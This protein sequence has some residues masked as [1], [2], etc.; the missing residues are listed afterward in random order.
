[1]GVKLNINFY[2]KC[3]ELRGKPCSDSGEERLWVKIWPG[4]FSTDRCGAKESSG[5]T[6]S[7]FSLVQTS[8]EV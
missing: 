8:A 6:G 1:M 2:E 5:I 3:V 4:F 7:V